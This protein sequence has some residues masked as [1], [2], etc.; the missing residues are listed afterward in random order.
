[1]NRKQGLVP[2]GEVFGGRAVPLKA[3]RE[4]SPQTRHHFTQA[5]QV[6]Q[7]VSASEA[8]PDLGFRATRTYI[9]ICKTLNRESHPARFPRALPEFFIKFLTDEDSVVVDIFSGSNTTGE[10]AEVLGRQWVSVEQQHDYAVLS[11]VRFMKNWPEKSIRQALAAI[12]SGDFVNLGS[13]DIP[14]V[15]NMSGKTMGE[16][17]QAAM[18]AKGTGGK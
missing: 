9:R 16:P 4:A 15:E 6:D 1:M 8:D 2:I 12:E 13:P 7:L 5:D 18:F 14:T 17:V 11:A 3:I 10:A